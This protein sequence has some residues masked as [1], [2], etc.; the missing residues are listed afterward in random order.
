M[1]HPDDRGCPQCALNLEAENMI[2]LFIWRRLM[3]GVAIIAVL[4]AGLLYYLLH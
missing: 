3:P 4:G 2:D 1:L